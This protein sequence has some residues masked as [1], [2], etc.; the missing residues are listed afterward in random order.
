MTRAR[1]ARAAQVEACKA[2]KLLQTYD[3]YVLYLFKVVY[4]Q[5]FKFLISGIIEEHT[6]LLPGQHPGFTVGTR[7]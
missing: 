1:A 7:S 5:E 4:G 6:L 3:H 2:P